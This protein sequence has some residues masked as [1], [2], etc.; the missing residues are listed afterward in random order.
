MM[1]TITLTM[2]IPDGDSIHDEFNLTDAKQT[3]QA[4]QVFLD[5]T[6]RR[7]TSVREA[8]IEQ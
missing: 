1:V 4:V 2:D 3:T 7:P 5:R 8:R 6:Y